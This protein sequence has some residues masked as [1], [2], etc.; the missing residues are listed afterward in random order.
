M[1]LHSLGVNLRKKRFLLL[2]FVDN[3]SKREKGIN[4]DFLFICNL[5][6]SLFFLNFSLE[7]ST[8]LS[9]HFGWILMREKY[10]SD[11]KTSKEMVFGIIENTLFLLVSRVKI[12][13]E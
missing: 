8:L 4:K 10:N 11:E 13:L 9:Q 12:I 3:K 6:N 5:L 7:D 2:L 1:A